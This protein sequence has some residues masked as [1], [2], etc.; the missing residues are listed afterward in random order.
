MPVSCAASGCKSRYTLEARE[1]GITFH[2]FPRSNPA[3]LDK[4]CRAMKRATST[5]ELWMPSRY[6]RLC[7]LHFQQS[8]FDT[9]GQTKRLRDDVIPSIFN[10]PEDSQ[11]KIFLQKPEMIENQVMD[12]IELPS[13]DILRISETPNEELEENMTLGTNIDTTSNCQDHPYFIPDIETLKKKL[14]VSEDSRAQ[15][16]KELRNAK[17]REKRLRQ[18]CRSIYQELR[19]RKLLCVQLQEVLQP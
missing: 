5:G 1:K 8:C 6:Q 18:T 7:S 11:M 14:Q 19:K 16:E 10:F 3:L 2:R 12:V 15:K 13:K 9:T 4:W 17:D